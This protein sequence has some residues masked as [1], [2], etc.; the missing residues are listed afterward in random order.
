M[1]DMTME[2]FM[3]NSVRNKNNSCQNYVFHPRH[4]FI[5]YVWN[6]VQ[7]F[8]TIYSVTFVPVLVSFDTLL[9]TKYRNE[10]N[11]I[12]P[13]M[14]FYIVSVVDLLFVLDV[15][16]MLNIA[17][18]TKSRQRREK[19]FNFNRRAIAAEYIN[20]KTGTFF[21]D[22]ISS[23][24]IDFLV[25]VSSGNNGKNEGASSLKVLR[26][27]RMAKLIRVFRVS[28]VSVLITKLEA[29]YQISMG[30]MRMVHTIGILLFLTNLLGCLWYGVWVI[31]SGNEIRC[32]TCCHQGCHGCDNLETV[33]CADLDDIGK[34][35]VY[36]RGLLHE[37]V[38]GFWRRYLTSVYWAFTT[39]STV[40]FGDISPQEPLEMLWGECAPLDTSTS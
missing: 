23:L 8:L 9:G 35:W 5:K 6:Y 30:Y 36:E 40:G 26:I 19:L 22:A 24:P 37:P 13:Q 20:P 28:R 7:T 18:K 29:K 21:V 16:V 33:L 39:L 17:I 15:L 12:D 4:P 38:A 34:G 25:S 31:E 1:R 3:K 2:D 14:G 32:L 27:G 11:D 10:E